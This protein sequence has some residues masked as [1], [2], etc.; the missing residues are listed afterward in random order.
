MKKMINSIFVLLLFGSEIFT[1]N[2]KIDG[3]YRCD[4]YS[5]LSRID[6]GNH[7][8]TYNFQQDIPNITEEI[9]IAKYDYMQFI[10]LQ[11]NFPK[12]ATE[13]YIYNNNKNIKT[14]NKLLFL[15]GKIN[16]SNS[17]IFLSYTTGFINNY[18][19]TVPPKISEQ[20]REY[21]DCTSILKEKNKTYAIENLCSTD[22]D[23]PWVEAVKGDGIGE[24]FTIINSWNQFYK[25]LLIMNGYISYNKP[26]LYKQNNR[27]KKI[28]VKGMKSGKSKILEVLDTPHPQTVDISFVTEPEDIRV[29]ISDVYKGSKYDDTCLHYCIT[30]D[31]EVIPYENSIYE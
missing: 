6:I 28:K 18:S 23:T 11:H 21:K 14:D 5:G 29:E 26:Y 31:E 19:L 30:F 27:I 25:Y 2:F 24:G 15:A 8:L 13:R 1:Q 22:S 17:I 7:T 3:K 12:E 20:I 16:G 10:I 4:V 9:N